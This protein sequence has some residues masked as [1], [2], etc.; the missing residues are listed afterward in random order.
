MIRCLSNRCSVQLS[1]QTA[2][3]LAQMSQE[4][5]SRLYTTGSPGGR[6]VELLRR[7]L[8]VGSYRCARTSR[9]AP[10]LG[11]AYLDEQPP[12]GCHVHVAFKPC[13]ATLSSLAPPIP[14]RPLSLT[15]SIRN[16]LRTPEPL[17]SPAVPTFIPRVFPSLCPRCW[18][19]SKPSF[20]PASPGSSR[21][22]VGLD[23]HRDWA[24]ADCGAE[25]NSCRCRYRNV[26]PRDNRLMLGSHLDASVKLGL[27][28]GFKLQARPVPLRN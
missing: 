28:V 20:P 21:T 12:R 27:L 11:N 8:K 24:Q 2:S 23:T 6:R 10:R 16:A 4:S 5:G 25:A 14:A 13:L 9:V 7:R 18:P 1:C 3:R 19:I 17:N 15:S 22:K 26:H